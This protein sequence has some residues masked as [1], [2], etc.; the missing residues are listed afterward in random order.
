MQCV[1]A[2]LKLAVETFLIAT[3]GSIFW[4]VLGQEVV[5][6]YA[7]GGWEIA[8]AQD[9]FVHFFI[10]IVQLY[11][12]YRFVR[13]ILGLIT[14]K[15]AQTVDNSLQDNKAYTDVRDRVRT[16]FDGKTVIPPQ[17]SQPE[18]QPGPR[19]T[20]PTPTPTPPS[21]Q[22]RCTSCGVLDGRVH[23]SGCQLNKR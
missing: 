2:A 18:P 23:L 7:S 12:L 3:V 22:G 9:T 17:R 4:M 5:S 11:L 14:K 10:Q 13:W 16:A 6:T 8:S 21:N 19:P 15:T 20:P 1:K